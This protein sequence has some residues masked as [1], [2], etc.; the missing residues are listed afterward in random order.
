MAAAVYT[1]CF[2][3]FTLLLEMRESE[4]ELSEHAAVCSAVSTPPRRCLREV[5]VGGGD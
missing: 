2:S 4:K 3:F 5:V 1:E